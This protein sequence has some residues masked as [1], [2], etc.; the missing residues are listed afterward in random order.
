MA[1]AD[2][3]FPTCRCTG[4]FRT[5]INR[6][7]EANILHYTTHGRKTHRVPAALYAPQARSSA[8]RCVVGGSAGSNKV[9]EC[10][11]LH[12]GQAA[13]LVLRHAHQLV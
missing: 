12:P 1:E 4:T 7:V 10:S 2:P 11:S 5:L 9:L 3:T 6:L 8:N 13:R